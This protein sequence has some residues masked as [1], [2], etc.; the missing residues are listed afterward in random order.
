MQA[1][2]SSPFSN[3]RDEETEQNQEKKWLRYCPQEPSALSGTRSWI[4]SKKG[5]EDLKAQQIQK[6]QT[7]WMF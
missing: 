2:V 7:S 4:T 1:A 5:K 6:Y 3:L